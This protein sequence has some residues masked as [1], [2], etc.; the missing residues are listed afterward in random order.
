MTAHYSLS[1]EQADMKSIFSP[2]EL[3]RLNP[4]TI[5]NHVAIIMDGN[6]RWAKQQGLPSMM[7][8]WE[9]PEVLTEVVRAASE[10]G[11]KTLTVYSF[12]TEN[13]ARSDQE[14][15]TLM[16]IFELYLLRNQECMIRDGIRLDAI[17]DLSRLPPP[18]Q[19]AFNQ[20]KKA[21]EQ[22]S[23]INL[24]L[25]LNYGGRDEIRR[26]VVKI[27]EAH[28]KT[29]FRPEDVTEELI[30]KHLDTGRWGDPDLLI[31]TSGEL[32]VSNF[33]LWQI[34]YSE[35]YVSDVLWPN[36]T[37][38]HL[39]EAVFAYQRRNRRMGGGV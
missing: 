9:G 38:R 6:R 10:I 19:R 17:G 21:T 28:E 24:I 4:L 32:R 18:V 2:E 30:A 26:A 37:P 23:K 33:L 36:F 8:H 29:N 1:F 34:S 25:A 5:P 11:I 7:G 16:N 3:A 22:C 39:F 15:E 20:T 31:R 13:W 27:I 14:V 12:S 35:I